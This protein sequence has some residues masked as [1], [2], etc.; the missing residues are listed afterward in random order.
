MCK[1]LIGTTERQKS[2]AVAQDMN[3]TR[4]IVG[5]RTERGNTER[6]ISRAGASG[7]GEGRRRV[8]PPVREA[9][10]GHPEVRTAKNLH[11]R[12]DENSRQRVECFTKSGIS[13]TRLKLDIV[14]R[15]KQRPV[16]V[17]HTSDRSILAGR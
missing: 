12:R 11:R 5:R 13:S 10:R 7:A 2:Y 9:E 16:S 1:D 4:M 14:C 6:P 8:P 17:R 15:P 3:L